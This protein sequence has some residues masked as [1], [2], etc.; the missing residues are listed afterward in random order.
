VNIV[1]EA[2]LGADAE[3]A[4]DQISPRI[5]SSGSAE[6]TDGADASTFAIG[7]LFNRIGLAEPRATAHRA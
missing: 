2:R 1:A 3:T 6:A 4:N 7:E 5:I